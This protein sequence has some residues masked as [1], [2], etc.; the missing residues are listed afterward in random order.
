M[1]KE[2]YRLF[3]KLQDEI[4]YNPSIII[5]L[6]NEEIYIEVTIFCKNNRLKYSFGKSFDI[7][8]ILNIA[9]ENLLVDQFINDTNYYFDSVY[10]K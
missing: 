9:N 10:N 7:Y 4:R 6:K 2:T 3:K 1:L 5:N 8:Q